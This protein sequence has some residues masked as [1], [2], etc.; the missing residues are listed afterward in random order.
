MCILR[1]GGAAVALAFVLGTADAARA[2]IIYSNDFEGAVGPEWS[3][4]R[5]D[6][7]P[8]G[9]R[10]LGLFGDASTSLT[11]TGLPAHGFVTVS[12]DLYLVGT[13]DGNAPIPAAGP[14]VWS[15]AADGGG[16]LIRTTFGQWSGFTTQFGQAYPDEF[17]GGVHP[18]RTGATEVRTLGYTAPFWDGGGDSVY[19]LSFTFP[20]TAG[21]VVFEFAA[22]L[23]DSFPP[24]E[25]WGIDNL[26]VS[27]GQAVPEPTALTVFATLTGVSGVMARRRRPAM[28]QR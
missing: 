14:D 25:L 16:P 8:S 23:S 21:S 3:V 1:T 22:D 19:S 15:L 4:N 27:V 18:F 13:W 9:R 20:H 28:N 6:I 11:L 2:E 10:F 26:R 7:T 24:N 5:T 12:F 17:P